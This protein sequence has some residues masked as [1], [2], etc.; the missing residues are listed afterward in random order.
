MLLATVIG[1]QF[2]DGGVALGWMSEQ[3][4]G[5]MR[6]I[7]GCTAEVGTKAYPW[8]AAA[9][10]AIPRR[11]STGVGSK[12]PATEPMGPL[13]L[14]ISGDIFRTGFGPACLCH[15]F[16]NGIRNRMIRALL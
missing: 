12:A 10:R 9:T 11:R 3:R 2:R 13:Y 5:Y 14:E 6:G 1:V 15:R 7:E 16:P 4:T 8:Q